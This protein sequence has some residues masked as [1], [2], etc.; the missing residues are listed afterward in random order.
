MD[1]EIDVDTPGRSARCSKL[2]QKVI[3]IKKE[4]QEETDHHDVEDA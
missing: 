1:V 3:Q 4:R 2:S